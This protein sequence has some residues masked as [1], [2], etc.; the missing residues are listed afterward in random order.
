MLIQK[1]DEIAVFQAVS[2]NDLDIQ[3]STAKAYPR[4][5]DKCIE[6]ALSLVMSDEEVAESC[7]YSL[8][9]RT[10]D[11][12]RITGPSARLAEIMMY[13]WGNIHAGS[14]ILGLNGR[15]IIAEAVAWDLENN[16][17]VLVE[18]KRNAAT[19]DGKLYGDSM[20]VVTGNAAASIAFRNAIFKNIPKAYWNPI[21]NAAI[22]FAVGDAKQLRV[23][24]QKVMERFEAIGLP[25]DKVLAYIEKKEIS[26]LT[27]DDLQ[28]LIGVGTAI[29]EGSLTIDEIILNHNQKSKIDEIKESFNKNEGF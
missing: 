17:K 10:K 29:K 27:A 9:E 21:L 7:F 15:S 12:G 18:V 16:N 22:K 4:V 24:I 14:R 23:K 19:K 1:K 2:Q 3:I 8:P 26:N 28:T 5:V 11:G 25:T 6:K 20:Q 13:C